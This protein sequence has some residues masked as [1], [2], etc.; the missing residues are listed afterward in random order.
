MVINYGTEGKP[1]AM[2]SIL[3]RGMTLGL[4]LE[5]DDVK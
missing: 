2:V 4:P 3:N 1:H 5:R